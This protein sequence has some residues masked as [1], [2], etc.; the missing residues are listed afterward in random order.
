MQ[1]EEQK[2]LYQQAVISH[3]TAQR[4]ATADQLAHVSGLL[5][6]ANQTIEEL[7]A[8]QPAPGPVE[9]PQGSPG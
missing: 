1:I 7:R 5:A 6:L 3:L 4:N 8:A 9:V 2:G